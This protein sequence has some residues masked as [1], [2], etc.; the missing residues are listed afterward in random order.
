MAKVTGIGGVFFLANGD[1]GKLSE[2]YQQHLGIALEPWGGGV[3]EWKQD[4]AEDGGL[5][6]WNVA[7]PDSDWF[8]PSAARFM[9]NYR[10]DDLETLIEQ[11]QK[12]NIDIVKGPEYHE[13]GVFAWVMD[14]EGNKIELWEPKLWDDKNKR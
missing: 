12:A 14:P 1:K 8:A 6:V 13:N 4:Q 11:L 2:W 10:V 3:L 9:I 7:E 5:T